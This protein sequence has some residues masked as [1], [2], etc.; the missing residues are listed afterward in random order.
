MNQQ[1]NPAK[2]GIIFS[3]KK[4]QAGEKKLFQNPDSADKQI[5]KKGTAENIQSPSFFGP[6]RF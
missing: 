4:T 1:T 3:R 6:E 5:Q 2:K